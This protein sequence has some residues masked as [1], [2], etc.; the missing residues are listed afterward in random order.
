MRADPPAGWQVAGADGTDR[1][2]AGVALRPAAGRPAAWCARC[3]AVPAAAWHPVTVTATAASAAAPRRPGRAVPS[4]RDSDRLVVTS[5][6]TRV[7]ADST[8][9]QSGGRNL[10][11]ERQEAFADE[12]YSPS[13]VHR[14]HAASTD[15]MCAPVARQVPYRHRHP[16]RRVA[17]PRVRLRLRR[18]ARRDAGIRPS[19]TKI[20]RDNL[21]ARVMPV[22]VCS[23]RKP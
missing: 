5:S 21:A 10:A 13:A 22:R 18:R 2:A 17:G 19:H 11:L 3:A 6:S 7:P 1:A 15:R 23:L 14:P 4:L 8:Q 9:L 20:A 16:R 12:P